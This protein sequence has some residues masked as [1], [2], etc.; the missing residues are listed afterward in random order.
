MIAAMTTTAVFSV[1]LSSF[2]SGAKADKRDAAA[3]ILRRAQEALKS[4]VS[5]D[6]TTNDLFP[7]SLPARPGAPGSP[8]GHWPAEFGNTYWALRPGMHDISSMLTGTPLEAAGASLRYTVTDIACLD[9]IPT[10]TAPN[11]T[12]ACKAVVFTLVYPD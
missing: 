12:Q 11:Y 10:G 7:G 5:V 9:D 6:P 3:M 1:I 4:Y 8:A 2:V